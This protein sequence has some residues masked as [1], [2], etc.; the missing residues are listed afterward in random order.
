MIVEITK[1]ERALRLTDAGRVLF[2]CPIGL[3][4]CP[5]GTKLGEGDCKTPEGE[6]RVVTRNRA[7]KY[8]RSLG[9]DYPGRADADRGL[10]RGAIDQAAHERIMAAH[11]LGLRPPWDTALGGYVMLHGGGA[12]DW[13]AGCVALDDRDMDFLFEKCEMGTRVIIRA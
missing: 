11:D 4:K 2:A 12:G 5:E 10:R 7:S 9:L 6:Y 8:H 3:G 13:T 1:S